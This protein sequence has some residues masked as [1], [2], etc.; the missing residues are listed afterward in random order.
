MSKYRVGSTEIRKLLCRSV[1]GEREGEKRG[2]EGR[3]ISD[4]GDTEV[5][6]HIIP[7]PSCPMSNPPVKTRHPSFITHTHHSSLGHQEF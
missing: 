7:I 3:A 5:L 4:R 6:L 1:E 2:R